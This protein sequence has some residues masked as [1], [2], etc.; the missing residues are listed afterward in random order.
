M[1]LKVGDPV[2]LSD[3]LA[4]EHTNAVV[5]QATDRIMAAVT[6]LVEDLRGEKA[7]EKRFDPRTA[8]VQE[9]GNPE[10]EEGLSMS[11]VA[12][13]GAG[14][15]GT[16]FSLVLADGGADVTLWGRREEVC[17]TDQREAGEHRLPPRDRTAAGDLRDP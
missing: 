2:D 14:S 1:H 15:W 16:A 7:P 10:E 4:K 5:L 12:V 9:I 17:T 8:G 6:S 11:K 13:F 3:L